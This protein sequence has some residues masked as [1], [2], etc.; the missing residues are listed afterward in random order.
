MGLLQVSGSLDTEQFWPKGTS[1]ADTTKVVVEIG[2]NAFRFQPHPELPFT[3]TNVFKGAKVRGTS[4]KAAIDSN[5]RITVRLQGIDAPELHYRPTGLSRSAG[6]A[7]RARFEKVNKE[8]RQ[9]FGE[10]AA[11]ALGQVLGGSGQGSSHRL[12]ATVETYVDAPNDVFDTYGRFVGDIVVQAGS[13]PLNLNQWLV[14]AGWA[15]PAFYSSMSNAEIQTYLDCAVA[16]RSKGRIW[17]LYRQKVPDFRPGLVYRPPSSLNSQLSTLNLSPSGLPGDAGSLTLPKL[18]R[19]QTCWYGYKKSAV[20][21][22]RFKAWLAGKGDELML[23]NDFL[24]NGVHSAKTR[25]L[26]SYL[27]SDGTFTLR[28]EDMVFKESTSSLVD[29]SGKEITQ[30]G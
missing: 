13:E 7:E 18:F 5:G 26:E 10:S 6:P 23:T 28:P 16:G 1:D 8:Y 19:R 24:A 27:Q 22:K 3:V 20:R 29:T 12:D 30:W 21:A 11:V 17:T 15:F 4:N 14:R 2:D 9:F 25:F